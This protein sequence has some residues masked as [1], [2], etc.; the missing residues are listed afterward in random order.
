M[1]APKKRLRAQTEKPWVR[2]RIF[3]EGRIIDDSLLIL[4]PAGL[5]DILGDLGA[6]H[7]ELC[8]AAEATGRP[9]LVEFEFWDGEFVRWGTDTARIVE[10]IDMRDGLANLLA[11]LERRWEE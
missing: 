6:Q 8:R 10:P 4:G 7:G 3:V 2:I 11:V 5:R 9:Y 1:T